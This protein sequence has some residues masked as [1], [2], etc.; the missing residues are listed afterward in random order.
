MRSTSKDFGGL[1]TI[2][3]EEPISDASREASMEQPSVPKPDP[4]PVQPDNIPAEMTERPQWVCW[5]W[6]WKRPKNKGTGKW[7]KPLF[8]A[9]TGQLASSTDADTWASFDEGFAAYRDPKNGFD[10]IGYVFSGDP[11]DLTGVD[12]DK[13]RDAET[14]EIRSWSEGQR[15]CKHWSQAA[16][17]PSE[18]IAQLSSYT[19]VSPSQ[20]GVKIFARAAIARGMKHGAVETYR[21]GR[22]FTV[23]GHKLEGTP[24]HIGD[25]SDSLAAIYRQF[26][27][28]GSKARV[29]RT[30]GVSQPRSSGQPTAPSGLVVPTIDQVIAGCHNAG[31]GDKFRRLFDGDTAGYPS[32]SEAELA[33]CSIIAFWSA[34]DA[35]LI[36]QVYR[37]SKLVRDKW[38]QGRGRQTYG[39][40]TISVALEGVRQFFDWSR[41]SDPANAYAVG[42]LTIVIKGA[43]KTASKLVVTLEIQR[44]GRPIDMLQVSNVLSSR[45]AAAN[46]IREWLGD[47]DE[48]VPHNVNELLATILVAAAKMVAGASQSGK[49]IR[50][51][52]AEHVPPE[53]SLQ[54]R[55]DNGKAFSGK[56]G[57]AIDRSKFVERFT[58]NHVLRL[59]ATGSDAPRG[60]GGPVKRSQLIALVEKEL[61]LLWGD[62]FADLKPIDAVDL[63]ADSP[64]GVAIRQA[65]VAIWTKPA[66]MGLHRQ[67]IEIGTA[68]GESV[69]LATRNSLASRVR[70]LLCDAPQSVSDRWVAVQEV[71]DAFVRQWH[72]PTAGEIR[73][74]LAMRF[75]LAQQIGVP[76]PGVTNQTALQ[77][78]GKKFNAVDS[79]PPVSD[80]M[81]G[82]DRLVILSHE[83]VGLILAEPTE[84]VSLECMSDSCREAGWEGESTAT[85]TGNLTDSGASDSYPDEQVSLSDIVTVEGVSLD[86]IAAR[87]R[88]RS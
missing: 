51:I 82:G 64:A 45:R 29:Q 68:R 72:G 74:L 19:E 16:P 25:C 9:R 76:I 24:S 49:T 3:S 13:C 55:L 43:R 52:L 12:L 5:R 4:C 62:L 40:L 26:D 36:D 71:F 28:Q 37:Q 18:I 73:T 2:C 41:N 59:A 54:Y 1:S 10:G 47:E 56:L 77:K 6:T 27:T 17:E 75:V 42:D 81:T 48:A 31:N 23:T 86:E 7:D 33:L 67:R 11:D 15:A 21:V 20:T 39:Q 87:Q 85:V 57:E 32:Q 80:R 58:N 38:D 78:L 46:C 69:Q 61:K 66:S 22:Y 84:E 83:L 34:G 44:D 70:R 79:R 50:E 8:N 14:G 65:I 63:P 88:A 53:I 35:G 30:A 60:E